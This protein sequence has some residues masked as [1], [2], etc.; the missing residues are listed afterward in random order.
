MF[1]IDERYDAQR[2]RQFASQARFLRDDE[3]KL[4]EEHF[5]DQGSDDFNAGLLAG[6]AAAHQLVQSVASSSEQQNYIAHMI[7]FVAERIERRAL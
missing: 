7:A 2:V 6:L 4:Y 1:I 3:R 5:T